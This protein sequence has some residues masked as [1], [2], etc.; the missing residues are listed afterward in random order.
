MQALRAGRSTEKRKNIGDNIRFDLGMG[1]LEEGQRPDHGDM[2]TGQSR[3]LCVV[4]DG[5]C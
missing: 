1:D 5:P 3:D 2:K 4:G